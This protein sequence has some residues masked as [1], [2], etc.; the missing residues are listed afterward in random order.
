MDNLK[1]NLRHSTSF[2]SNLSLSQNIRFLDETKPINFQNTN[3]HQPDS[4]IAPVPNKF[5]YISNPNTNL[6]NSR[7]ETA[8]IA[9]HN[10]T[11][12]DKSNTTTTA[13]NLLYERIRNLEEVILKKKRK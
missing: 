13:D 1:M 8:D 3:K 2:E 10:G 7:F 12:E 4:I 5:D 9:D 6:E 11:D